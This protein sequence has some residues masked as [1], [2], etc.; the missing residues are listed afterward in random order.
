MKK[1]IF[2]LLFAMVCASCTKERTSA[3]GK[4]TSEVRSP[5][6]FN[7]VNASGSNRVHIAYG[8]SFKVELRGSDNL[9]PHF[10]TKVV[11][12]ELNLGYEDFQVDDD[13]IEVFVTLPALH[14]VGLSGSGHVTINGAFPQ[15]ESIDFHS[16]GSGHLEVLD[17]MEAGTVSISI[18]GSGITDAQKLRSKTANVQVSG[19]GDVKVSPQ[20]TMNVNVSGSGTI[21]YTGSPA[22]ESSVSGSGKIIRL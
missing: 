10:K 18:S 19:S 14:G 4:Q 15:Q 9:V 6:S 12:D 5:G 20:E 3:N 16:S 11:G 13:D 21:Y 2:L 1:Q 7:N 8:S 22:I 17:P